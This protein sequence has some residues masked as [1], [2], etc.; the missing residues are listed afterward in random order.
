MKAWSRSKAPYIINLGTSWDGWFDSRPGC[1][2]SDSHWTES[3]LG[4]RAGKVKAK[5]HFTPLATTLSL[6]SAFYP[7]GTRRYPLYRKLGGPQGRS[8][9]VWKISPT[10]RFD[11]RTVQ[12]LSSRYTDHANSAHP[13]SL[14]ARIWRRDNILVPVRNRN[15]LRTKFLRFLNI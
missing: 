8:G 2:T 9:R 7:R 12:P 4:P 1:F 5:V 13:H 3:W 10:P 14:S 6:T 15:N 11:P